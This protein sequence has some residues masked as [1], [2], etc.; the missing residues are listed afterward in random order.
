VALACAPIRVWRHRHDRQLSVEIDNFKPLRSNTLYGFADVRVVEL[1]LLI[2][3]L[4]VHQ[5]A[6]K[7]WANLPAKPL[8]TREGIVRRDD[9]GKT[10]YVP[11][12]EFTDKATRNAFS[13]R[14]IATL[15]EYAPAA[16]DDQAAA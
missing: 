9:Q 4:S 10:A 6:G 11:I 15:L 14:V 12:L 3:D 7:R 16:F 1:H 2:H 8:I 5:K 13:D